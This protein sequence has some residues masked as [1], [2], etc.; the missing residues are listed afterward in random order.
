MAPITPKELTEG[1]SQLPFASRNTLREW[2]ALM[3]IE[4]KSSEE[5]HE[6]EMI[7]GVLNIDF[8]K[9][10]FDH[11]G[12][13]LMLP[14]P[15]FGHDKNILGRA[16][17]LTEAVND[18]AGQEI[19]IYENEQMEDNGY[20][21]TGVDVNDLRN[22]VV[23][24]IRTKHEILA[25]IFKNLQDSPTTR[26]TSRKAITRDGSGDYWYNK[27]RI[28]FN[29][30]RIYYLIFTFLFDRPDGEATYK[31]INA[32]LA[33]QG[34]N[35]CGTVAKMSERIRNAI[36]VYEKNDKFPSKIG[37]HKVF[38][39]NRGAGVRLYNPEVDI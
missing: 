36:K 3:S 38:D 1:L 24:K 21:S 30:T 29:K 13:L 19:M 31:E 6:P 9:P 23:I 8:P 11:K 34:K 27:E 5:S 18:A 15:P 7:H 25:D 39:T 37:A 26:N 2:G 22:Y 17:K 20:C 28:P 4:D 14:T 12:G 10:H 16:K 33:R 35:S 32:H